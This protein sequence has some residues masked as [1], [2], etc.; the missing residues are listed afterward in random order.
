MNATT[1]LCMFNF[2]QKL[3]KMNLGIFI[4]HTSGTRAGTKINFPE[5]KCKKQ[6]QGI[7]NLNKNFDLRN[8]KCQK[9]GFPP[10][11]STEEQSCF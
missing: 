2:Q 7:N 4:Y 6:I 10:L 5:I 3:L 11:Q 9:R 1:D 8:I